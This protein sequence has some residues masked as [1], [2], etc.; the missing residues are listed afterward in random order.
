RCET[1]TA[2][3]AL[4]PVGGSPGI[5]VAALAQTT[6]IISLNDLGSGTYHGFPGGLYPGSSNAPPAGHQAAGLQMAAQ[7]VPRNAAGAPDPQGLIVMI[8][9]GMSN[10]THEYGA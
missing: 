2:A 1:R 3:A 9:V 4:L 6:G 5:E 8:A 7:I 10:T